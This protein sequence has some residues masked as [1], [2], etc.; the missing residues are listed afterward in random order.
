MANNENKEIKVKKL[1][2]YI[3]YEL[4]KKMKEK[5]PDTKFILPNVKEAVL[6]EKK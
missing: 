5:D 1:N 4:L 2:S 6:S 3:S